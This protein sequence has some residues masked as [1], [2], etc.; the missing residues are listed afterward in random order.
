LPPPS[1]ISVGKELMLSNRNIF[2]KML[3]NNWDIAK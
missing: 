2:A 3:E 1:M